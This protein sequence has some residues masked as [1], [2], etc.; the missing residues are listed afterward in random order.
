MVDKPVKCGKR[1]CFEPV[2][3]LPRSKSHSL[4]CAEHTAAF[5]RENAERPVPT[6]GLRIF[7]PTPW[8]SG[9]VSPRGQS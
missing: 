7:N 6:T 4:F 9:P 3:Y 8:P 5:D 1:E 2:A